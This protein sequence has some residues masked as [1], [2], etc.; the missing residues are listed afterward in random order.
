[1]QSRS[2]PLIVL[3]QIDRVCDSFEAAWHAGLKPRIEDF[4]GAADVQERTELF[5][6]LLAREVELRRKAG[7]NPAPAEYIKRFGVYSELIQTAMN[8]S[9][10]NGETA[11][12]P[13]TTTQHATDTRTADTHAV[14]LPNTT[15]T[16]DQSWTPDR[17]SS[18]K[19]QVPE[20]IGRFRPSRLLGKGNFLVFLARDEENGREVAIKIARP[21]DPFGRKRLLTLAEEAQRLRALDHPGI[22]RMHEFVAPNLVEGAEDP[23]DDGF[24]VLEY[25]EGTTLEELYSND[26]PPLEHL[27]EILVKV[28]DAV[29]YAHV[30]GLVHRDLKPSNILLDSQGNPRVCDFGL[31]VDEEIQRMRRGEVAGTLP[32]MAPE[33]VRGETNRLDGRTDIWSLGVILYRGLTRRL[34]FRGGSTAEYFEEILHR[35]PRPP[36]QCRDGIPR[37]LE[38]ICLRCLCRPMSERYITAHDFADDLRRWLLQAC[39]EPSSVPAAPPIAPKGLRAFGVEDA[40]SF[41]GLLPG[42]RGSDGIPDSI[43]FWKTKVEDMDGEGGFC[44]GLIYGPSGGGKSSFVKAGLLPNLERERVRAI[45]L[46]VTPSG[47]EARILTELRRI[48]P[49]LPREGDLADALGILRDDPHVRPREKILLVLDQ[50]EQW[51]EGRPIDMAAELIRALRQC[52]GRHVAAILLVR[53]DFWMA[54]TRLFRAVEIPLVEGSNTGAVELFDARHTRFVLEEFGRSLGLIA[55]DEPRTGGKSAAFLTKAVEGLV[56]PDGRVMPVRL[57]LFVEVVRRRPWTVQTLSELGGVEGIGVKFLEEAFDSALATPARRLHRKAVESVL[58]LLLPPPNSMIRGAPRCRRELLEG[59]GYGDSPDDFAALLQILDH[60]LRL[61]T[62]TDLDGVAPGAPPHESRSQFVVGETHYQLA[63]DYLIRPIR[64]WVQRNERSS[65]AGRARLRLEAVTASWLERPRAHQLPSFLEYMGILA[66]TSR[67][68]WSSDERRLMKAAARHYFIRAAAA[69]AFLGALSWAG[70]EYRDRMKA[71]ALLHTAM[72]ADA[73]KLPAILDQ[74]DPYHSVLKSDLEKLEAE[75]GENSARE[76]ASLL[77][78]RH[79]PTAERAAFLRD[80]LLSADPERIELIRATLQADPLI[81]GC[82][83]LWNIVHDERAD[84]ARRLRAAA[85]LA[86]LEPGNPDWDKAGPASAEAM[87][88]EPR[89]EIPHWVGLFRPVLHTLTHTLGEIFRDEHI[90]ASSR[91]AASEAM[92]KVLGYLSD[93][94][95]LAELATGPSSTSL[96]NL[97][98][99]HGRLNHTNAAIVTG[100]AA[101]IADANPD[102][103]RVLTRELE[104]LD[105]PHALVALEKIL[106]ETEAQPSDEQ[107]KDRDA[108]RQANAAVALLV[109]GRPDRFWPLLR[110]DND[111]RLRCLLIDRLARL[112]GGIQRVIEHLKERELDSVELQALLMILCEITELSKIEFDHLSQASLTSLVDRVRELYLNHPHPGVHSAAELLLRRMRLGAVLGECDRRLRAGSKRRP[113]ELGWLPG[114]NGHTLVVVPAPLEFWMGSPD[115]EA[116]RFPYETRHYVRIPRSIAVTSKEVT[117]EQYRNFVRDFRQE[118]RYSQGP[119]C[120]ANLVNFFEAAAYC[121]WLS[122]LDGIDESHWCYSKKTESGM[123]VQAGSVE[124]YGYR[125]PTEAEWEYLCR[126]GTDTA[127]PFGSS[128]ELFSRYGWTWLNSED[129]TRP[130]G[131]LLPNELGLFDVLGNVWEWVHFNQEMKNKDDL[132]P[133]PHGTKEEPAGDADSESI[134]QSFKTWRILRG[135]AFDYSPAQSR[136]S[137]RYAATAEYKEGTISFRVVRTLPPA[138]K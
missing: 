47:T 117:I 119:N 22:V 41:L 36:R 39:G 7:E 65:K 114:P 49:H 120:P 54:T 92:A 87:L 21:A 45:Y 121:N 6:E 14:T 94:S 33:Q 125:L 2:L 79:R 32:Y 116:T 101:M 98:E 12:L 96:R 66:H 57:S 77:L 28:A 34:P 50:F 23:G 40:G 24:I 52:D 112:Q 93:A 107:A 105:R 60:D 109:L 20:K 70:M 44:L 46:E 63:H 102:A 1:M 99:D 8:E 138:G 29:H 37:E 100:L 85:A 5:R 90:D 16:R 95:A 26:P 111:P 11:L 76:I 129:T 97:I 128:A 38:R 31:A 137:H 18:A 82:K 55:A 108:G 86:F 130:V 115:Q 27:V 113:A 68:E 135:G 35:E 19:V 122:K 58:K 123:V 80:C 43:R 71:H 25:I 53:D 15:A 59:S 61:I 132:P 84:R 56:E 9:G 89:S 17:Y 73:Q 4:L 136:S 88:G 67:R 91:A 83:D 42:P 64:Q 13:L 127:R 74:L 133:Y 118:T 78:H 134:I 106:A 10:R 81:A 124:R 103:F 62:A 51:L 30:A 3:Q 104:R 69:V 131:D 48:V 110:H 75:P 126:A 72:Q